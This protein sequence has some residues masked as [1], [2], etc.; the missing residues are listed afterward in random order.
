MGLEVDVLMKLLIPRRLSC[1]R[2]IL[3]FRIPSLQYPSPFLMF[4]LIG[5]LSFH[6]RLLE[7]RLPSSRPRER[8]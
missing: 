2:T 5:W 8:L 6:P 7:N 4:T 3:N 1:Y